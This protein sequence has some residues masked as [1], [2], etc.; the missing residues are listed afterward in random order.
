MELDAAAHYQ[1]I[2]ER[3]TRLLVAPSPKAPKIV[4][5]YRN[6]SVVLL[7]RKHKWILVRYYDYLSGKLVE[8]WV[9]KKHLR[10]LPVQ[11]KD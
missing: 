9:M 11:N 7:Q 8:G 10:R 3:H 5:L 2:V 1:Y 4:D 6:Q